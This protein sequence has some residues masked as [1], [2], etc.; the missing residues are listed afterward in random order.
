MLLNL[1]ELGVVTEAG[2]HCHGPLLRDLKANTWLLLRRQDTAWDSWEQVPRAEGAESL[3][4]L[5]KFNK[6]Q[7]L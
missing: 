7:A 4:F 6:R 3:H 2:G 5:V 1:G